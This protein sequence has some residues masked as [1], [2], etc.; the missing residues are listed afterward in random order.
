MAL[1]FPESLVRAALSMRE[2]VRAVEAMF[3]ELGEGGAENRPRQRVR[4]P[5]GCSTR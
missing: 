2:A 4:I 1:Y 5:D 3:R